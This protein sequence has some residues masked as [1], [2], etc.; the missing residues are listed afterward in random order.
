METGCQ[1]T[2]AQGCLC[3]TCVE[4]A[5]AFPWIDERTQKVSLRVLV[6]N[7]NMGMYALTSTVF[8]FARSGHVWK[9]IVVQSFRMTNY[10]S[11]STTWVLIVAMVIWCCI[12][13]HMIRKET[14]E[15]LEVVRRF[16]VKSI[17]DQY[18]GFWN[19]VDWISIAGSIPVVTVWIAFDLSVS[20][21]NQQMMSMIQ[22]DLLSD[23]T[24]LN[25]LYSLVDTVNWW[26]RS[27]RYLL[28]TYPVIVMLRLFK[29]F[30]EQ[31]RLALVTRTMVWC[32]TDI[33]HFGLVLL[34]IFMTYAISGVCLFGQHLY[35]YA[36]IERAM[37]TTFRMFLGD[38]DWH[39][40]SLAGHVPAGIYYWTFNILLVMIALNVLLAIILDGYTHIKA[41]IGDDA[42]TLVSQSLEIYNRW[43]QV[44]RKQLIAIE[45][46]LQAFQDK[47]VE[48][49][50]T[51]QFDKY[52]GRWDAEILEEAQR[53]VLL[54]EDLI[55]VDDVFL[56]VPEMG[57]KQARDLMK[58]GLQLYEKEYPPMTAE[59]KGVE[60]VH[61]DVGTIKSLVAEIRR[62]LQLRRGGASAAANASEGLSTRFLRHNVRKLAALVED[63]LLEEDQFQACQKLVMRHLGG[64]GR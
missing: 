13:I 14:Q 42:E 16:G 24:A 31:P 37:H 15:I 6:F 20:D 40:L 50:K 58:G 2:G 28:S 44:R 43:I 21:V 45:G 64:L 61:R 62:D 36:N 18:I 46:V 33:V 23:E 26:A 19:V 27:Q 56:V 1:G 47:E 30:H 57:K 9:D 41:K 5:N 59:E 60:D 17:Y 12:L 54:R 10:G 49:L 4:G 63:E 39:D 38:S 11:T 22:S 8:F 34:V 32:G 35:Y 51:E 55:N 3:N 25:H 53:G 48:R 52:N 7:P 29:S